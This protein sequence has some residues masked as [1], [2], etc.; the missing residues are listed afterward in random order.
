MICLVMQLAFLVLGPVNQEAWLY[1]WG[2][3]PQRVIA[4]LEQPPSTWLDPVLLGIVTA[5][6]VHVDWLHLVGNLAYL[7]VFGITVERAVGH[8]R[9]A[10]LF[11]VLGALANLSVAWQMPD[12]S[13][14]V[15]GASGGVS[16]I[17]GVYLGLFPGRRMGLWIPLGLYLQ[18]A[19]VPALLVIG[20]WFTLQLLYSVFG[21]ISGTVAWWSHIAGFLLGLFAAVLLRLFS[22]KINFALRED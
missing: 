6:F 11:L 15:I 19:R 9:L 12:T 21:P 3:S 16:A 20:S 7:W 5:L 1:F 4:L 13:A 8:L 18:F 22:R 17:I 14:Q 10:L 2:F